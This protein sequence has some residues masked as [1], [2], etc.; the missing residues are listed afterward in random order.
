M[1][2]GVIRQ[3]SMTAFH[4]FRNA[5]SSLGTLTPVAF[6]VTFLLQPV[7]AQDR[8]KLERPV[9]MD[10]NGPGSVLFILDASGTLHE[11][12]VTQ[13]SLQEYGKV[14]LPKELTAADMAFALVGGRDSLLIAG[15]RAGRG[16]VVDFSRDG[17]VLRTWSFHNICSGIDFSANTQTAYVATSDSNELYQLDLGKAEPTFLTHIE[18]ATKLGPVGFDEAR[19][20]IFVADVASGN[21][22]QYSISSKTSKVLVSGLSAPTALAFDAQS[23][24]LF[25][26]DPGRGGIFIIDTRAANPVLLS[27]AS[28]ALKSPYGMTLISGSRVAVADYGANKAIV[29]SARGETLFRFPPSD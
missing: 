7:A 1:D 14:P 11:F 24:R 20:Q 4:Y 6:A 17:Q 16:V 12:H 26:A 2:E 15:T 8:A 21:V 3:D 13:N 9:M 25:V 23:N 28:N 10:S 22:Y 19:K 29:L 27:F 5:F 18:E